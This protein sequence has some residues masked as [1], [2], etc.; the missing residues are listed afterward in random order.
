M[1]SVDELLNAYSKGYFPMAHPD[2]NN[3]IYWHKPKVRGIIPLDDSFH[4]PK[5]LQR[6]I[7]QN[8]YLCT[9]NKSFEE[10][11]R[12][13]SQN[14]SDETWISEEII[15]SYI[16]LHRSGYAQSI[17]TWF[18]GNLV[19]GLYG[20]SLGRAFFGESMFYR[21]TDASKV[22][23]VH[24]VEL[25]R[26]HKFMLLDSQYLNPHLKQFGAYQISDIEYD[27]LLEKALES[28]V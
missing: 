12:A 1:L 6:V 9:S 18:D 13:C 22:A 8:K 11:I 17:E 15:Q 26:R 14:R 24:L 28:E 21:A 4:I 25:L 3:R 23:L 16:A 2:R 19:G 5:N 7:R 20:V 10:V 27:S